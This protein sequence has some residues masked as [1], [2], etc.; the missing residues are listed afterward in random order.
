MT[1]VCSPRP[2]RWGGP[3]PGGRLPWGRRR[4]Q[5]RRRPR[6]PG[7][8]LAEGDPDSLRAYDDAV[9]RGVIPAPKG[10]KPILS[11][12][13]APTDGAAG[14]TTED[15]GSAPTGPA[16]PEEAWKWEGV[17]PGRSLIGKVEAGQLRYYMDDDGHGPRIVGL[18]PAWP[19]GE[20]WRT[21]VSACAPTARPA[22]G[23][24]PAS[25]AAHWPDGER[26]R[27]SPWRSAWSSACWCCVGSPTRR[28]WRRPSASSSSTARWRRCPCPAARVTSGCRSRCA[29]APAGPA[30]RGARHMGALRGVRLLRADWHDMGVVHDRGDAHA[31]RGALV[32]RPRLRPARPGR[33]GPPGGGVGLGPDVVRPR[34]LPGAPGAVGRGVVPRRRAGCAL[35][36]RHRGGARTRP[37]PARPRTR[38]C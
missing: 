30:A 38:H 27:S 9:A 32:A 1:R 11:A 25:A 16:T 34:G 5:D 4:E 26:A 36:C 21:A 6:G 22:T 19:P 13:R 10:P 7:V 29:G 28:A 15:F 23:S 17:P 2:H 24:V 33:A 20:R 8:E 12:G 14:G 37:P 31:H 18:P 35:V 3:P